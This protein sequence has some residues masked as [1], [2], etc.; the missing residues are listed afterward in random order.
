MEPKLPTAVIV[1]VALAPP[2]VIVIVSA[3]AYAV[4]GAFIAIE[5]TEPALAIISTVRSL[6]PPPVVATPVAVT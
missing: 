6:L 3:A 4:P 5:S 2:P 1:N